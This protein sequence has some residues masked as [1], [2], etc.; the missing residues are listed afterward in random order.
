MIWLSTG[1]DAN[2]VMRLRSGSAAPFVST[3]AVPDKSVTQ[4]STFVMFFSS[5]RLLFMTWEGIMGTS[6]YLYNLIIAGPSYSPALPVHV[7]PPEPTAGVSDL[8][9]VSSR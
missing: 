2:P 8:T 5:S 3:T 1:V 4:K 6:P 9:L 7:Y